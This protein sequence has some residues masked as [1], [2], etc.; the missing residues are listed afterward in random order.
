M[1]TPAVEVQN[2]TSTYGT[3][4]AVDDLSFHVNTGELYALL[5]TNGAGKTTALETIEGHRAPTGGTVTVV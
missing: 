4:T 1:P 3:F 2:L 5:G